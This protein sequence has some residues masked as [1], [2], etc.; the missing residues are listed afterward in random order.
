MV[1]YRLA[2]PWDSMD[3]GER[4]ARCTLCGGKVRAGGICQECGFDN[5]KNDSKYR[6]NIHNESGMVF[7]SGDCEEHL[8]REHERNDGERKKA[9]GKAREKELK[10]Q[11]QTG[12]VKKKHPVL[13]LIRWIIVFL[14][15]AQI[16]GGI[17]GE[18]SYRMVNSYY[19]G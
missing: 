12:T 3:G 11:R 13:R 16:L 1:R 17:V 18:I 19:Y 8:N 10:K 2:D 14:V 15:A 4:M 7:H 5:S 6:L 9:S